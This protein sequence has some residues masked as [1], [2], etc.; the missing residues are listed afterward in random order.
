MFVAIKLVRCLNV[1]IL[2]KLTKE[3]WLKLKLSTATSQWEPRYEQRNK[4]VLNYLI[5]RQSF[6]KVINILGNAI[7]TWHLLCCTCFCLLRWNILGKGGNKIGRALCLQT[8]NLLQFMGKV[9]YY[10]NNIFLS[11]KVYFSFYMLLVIVAVCR[12]TS[13]ST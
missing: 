12:K 1:N 13:E 9:L 7:I 4:T 10:K 3:K 2:K 11:S 6:Y 5:K 8:F